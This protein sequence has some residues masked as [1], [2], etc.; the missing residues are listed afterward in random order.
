MLPGGWTQ[1]ARNAGIPWPRPRPRTAPTDAACGGERH[2]PASETD[3]N[4]H[5]YFTED[6]RSD[7]TAGHRLHSL[8]DEEEPEEEDSVASF[9]WCVFGGVWSCLVCLVWRF[10]W[11]LI[12]RRRDF[13]GL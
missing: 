2:L 10:S 4:G 7:S 12:N 13:H 6:V 1:P 8:S 11:T 5:V 9:E 3:L